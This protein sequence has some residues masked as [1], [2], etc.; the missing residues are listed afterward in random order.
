MG[1][2]SGG[3]VRLDVRGQRRS[4]AEER[5]ERKRSDGDIGGGECEIGLE[6]VENIGFGGIGIDLV[7][8][9]RYGRGWLSFMV[10]RKRDVGVYQDDEVVVFGRRRCQADLGDRHRN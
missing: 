2:T 3:R 9:I 5:V 4:S 8:W 7:D 10:D 1:T 6:P